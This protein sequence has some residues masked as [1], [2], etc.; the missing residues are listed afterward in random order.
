MSE[1]GGHTL[2]VANNN[3]SEISVSKL[4]LVLL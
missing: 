4:S 3:F 1:E 2:H